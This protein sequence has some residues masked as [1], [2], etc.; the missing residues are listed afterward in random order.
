MDV[1]KVLGK[2]AGISNGHP[3]QHA[4]TKDQLVWKAGQ[5][6]PLSPRQAEAR[7]ASVTADQFSVMWLGITDILWKGKLEN[8]GSH[9]LLFPERN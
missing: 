2:T 7:T 1:P 4:E 6:Q 9:K 5:N 3:E 8:Q